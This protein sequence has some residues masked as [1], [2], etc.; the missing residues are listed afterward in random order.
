MAE[1]GCRSNLHK[2]CINN[3]VN[4]DDDT[5]TGS[6]GIIIDFLHEAQRLIVAKWG[7]GRITRLE[8]NGARTPLIIDVPHRRRCC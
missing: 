2:H 7:E 6:G 3:N 5:T 1:S 4:T 8:E